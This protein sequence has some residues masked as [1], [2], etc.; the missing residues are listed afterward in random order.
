MR[1]KLFPYLTIDYKAGESMLN[2]MAARGWE[3][4]WLFLGLFAI[5]KRTER[6]DLRYFVDFGDSVYRE[7]PEYLTLCADAGWVS[8]GYT[9]S[10]N[11]YASAPG[12]QPV[13]LQTDSALEYERFRKLVL[14]RVRTSGLVYAALGLCLL[15]NTLSGFS[16]FWPNLCYLL[17]YSYFFSFFLFSLPA[18]LVGGGIYMALLLLRVRQWR[19]LTVAGEPIPVPERRGARWRSVLTLL[20]GIYLLLFESCYILD[21]VFNFGFNSQIQIFLIVIAALLTILALFVMKRYFPKRRTSP[22]YSAF[23]LCGMLLIILI[24]LVVPTSHPFQPPHTLPYAAIGDED[25]SASSSGSWLGRRDSWYEHI[26]GED[27][28]FITVEIH[29]LRTDWL[30]NSIQEYLWVEGMK[31]VPGREGIWQADMARNILYG[32]LTVSSSQTRF[33]DS[34]YT[35]LLRRDNAILLVE[36]PPDMPLN[37]LLAYIDSWQ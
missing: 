24:N 28:F 25:I 18:V 1:I 30:T 11:L 9:R 23:I 4:K 22:I 8:V 6:T 36:Y 27:N 37:E 16:S 14:K 33:N 17:A 32:Y 34:R 15:L 10:M 2:R 20:S 13:P 31:P 29:T 21:M 35:L 3:L 19:A 7:N 26:G 5:F 12:T